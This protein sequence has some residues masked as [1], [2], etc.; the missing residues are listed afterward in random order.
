LGDRGVGTLH[1]SVFQRL[2]SLQ[3]SLHGCL[4]SASEKK[5]EIVS[6]LQRLSISLGYGW[7][8]PPSRGAI[9]ICG[10]SA[11][12]SLRA[13]AEYYN[14]SEPGLDA[15]IDQ[16]VAAWLVVAG[17]EIESV[18]LRDRVHAL[19]FRIA[20]RVFESCPDD[21]SFASADLIAMRAM[22][23][24]QVQSHEADPGQSVVQD[25]E[26]E[27][28]KEMVGA[29]AS[30][31]ENIIVSE[32]EADHHDAVDEAPHQPLWSSLPVVNSVLESSLTRRSALMAAAARSSIDS[33]ISCLGHDSKRFIALRLIRAYANE[34]IPLHQDPD[35]SINENTANRLPEWSKRLVI[36]EAEE[37]EED[38]GTVAQ[39][40]PKQLMNDVESWHENNSVMDERDAFGR[41]AL[42]LAFLD[43]ADIAARKGTL[44]R[45][46]LTSYIR[47]CKS[48]DAMLDLAM[49]YGSTGS[50]GKVKLNTFVADIE[51]LFQT[52][53]NTVELVK[54]AAA[55]VVF[56]TVEVLPT[57]SKTWWEVACP[58]Y[59]SQAVKDFVESTVSPQIL[60]RE[61]SRI[62]R[63][64][65]FGDMTVR[66]SAVSREVTALYVQDDFTLTVIVKMPPSFP[67]GRAE[68][69]CSKTLGV[70]E[71]RTKRWSLQIS[72]M[73]N[74]Q[75][76]TLIDA[77]IL[78]RENVDKEFE[79]VEPCP[80]CYSVLH[81]KTHKLP[82]M[83]CK[84]CSNRFH[85]DCL[86]QW[87]RS[88][89][90]SAC[91]VCQQPWSGTRVS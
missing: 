84:T 41:M 57:V 30:R 37:L 32:L 27:A 33:I 42:W 31:W 9:S 12:D 11:S 60:R 68:V 20:A 47:H 50:D 52:K 56:R 35:E 77:L 61:L 46:A 85:F 71:Q 44:I 17:R 82:E 39:W 75:G 86:T 25:D 6:T 88:S 64:A 59:C 73:L 22:H 29:F 51:E 55:S 16:A 58:S 63:Y 76:G 19:M 8:T 38:V 83:Q 23:A 28:V 10:F 54:M 49:A 14:D 90:K 89:G 4:A 43:I 62:K 26:A 78:W 65:A 70:P 66:G 36:E 87:F 7:N 18:D 69:D 40:I 2:T 72:L 81:V 21:S 91:V 15:D 13:I 79:G 1:F 67:F 5:D 24:A 53:K 45:P 80:V 48:A 34:G 74:N 3:S